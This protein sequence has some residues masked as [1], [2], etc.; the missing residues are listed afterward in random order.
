MRKDKLKVQDWTQFDNML[1][2]LSDENNEARPIPADIKSIIKGDDVMTDA[3][4]KHIVALF[5]CELEW[6]PE[7]SYNFLIKM[8]PGLKLRL[9]KRVHEEC[10][11]S[12][13]Y[14]EL[15]KKEAIKIIGILKNIKGRMK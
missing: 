11:L 14:K 2:Q 8:T 6:E 7:R 1:E 15:K 13:V 12:G 10:D 4:H 5:V 9:P 3:Q